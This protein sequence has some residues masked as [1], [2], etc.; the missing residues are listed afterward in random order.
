MSSSRTVHLFI[1]YYYI[2]LFLISVQYLTSRIFY[3]EA[4]GLVLSFLFL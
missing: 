1:F 2:M 4:L 3:G